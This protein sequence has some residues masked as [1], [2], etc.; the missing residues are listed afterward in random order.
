MPTSTDPLLYNKFLNSIFNVNDFEKTYLPNI[1]PKAPHGTINSIYNKDDFLNASKKTV[2]RT[3]H[4]VIN[5]IFNPK[6]FS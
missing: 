3:P 1:K 6:D 5:A 2:P 4:N